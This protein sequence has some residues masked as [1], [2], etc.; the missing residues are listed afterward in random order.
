MS[1]LRKAIRRT[2]MTRGMRVLVALALGLGA[3]MLYLLSTASA[4]TTLFAKD[5]PLLL[6]LGVAMVVALLLL[7][8]YQLL[9]LKRRLNARVF[10]SKLTLRLVML[11]SLVAVLPGAL[12]YAVSVQFLARS[13]E[14]WFDVRVDKALEGGLS[15][16]RLNLESRLKELQRK[17]DTMALALSERSA[18]RQV[19]MLNQLREQAGL[20]EAA[21]LST[22]GSIIAFASVDS[23]SLMPSMPAASVL[24]RVR[25]GRCHRGIAADRAGA[26]TAGPG[27][28]DGAGGLQ[29]LPGAVVVARR[30]QAPV[31]FDPDPVAGSRDV[32]LA[33]AR[34]PVQ[35][36]SVSAS[37]ISRRGHARRRAGRFQSAPSGAPP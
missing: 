2:L 19:S 37:R 1:E 6:A 3:L 33:A 28:G 4:N 23:S 10:G 31:H 12:V 22:E 26:G 7:V 27:R 14:S 24:R 21:L 16:G 9:L 25:T 18:A 35:R 13:I 20:H 32:V 15:L 29:R 30:P 11:F 8:G 34:H 5:L 36:A 17:G